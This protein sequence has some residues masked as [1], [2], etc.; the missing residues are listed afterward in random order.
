MS[1][2]PTPIAPG[3]SEASA[4]PAGFLQNL[5]DIY[6]APREA[7]TR[8]VRTGWLLPAL[9]YLVVTLAG[10]GIWI[11]H[12]DPNEFVKA[13]MEEFGGK[14]FENATPEERSQAIDMQSRMFTVSR[15]VRAAL[16]PVFAIL[17]PAAVLLFI[18]RFF[19]A[20]DVRFPQALAIVSWTFLAVE[21]V[22]TPLRLVVM[23][24]KGEWNI[25]PQLAVQASPGVWA[26][27]SWPKWQWGLLSVP[28]LFSLW[29]VFLLATGF[30]VA[31]RRSTGSALWGVL[32]P[33]VLLALGGVGVMAAFMS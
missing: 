31:T 10:T 21:L 25:E 30:A 26:D 19:Y 6:F 16:G 13:Q 11:S 33:W 27:P 20:G 8:I 28:D 5:I 2:S 17:V 4:K 22:T 24:L 15:W 18:F 29:M 23:W 14:R 1:E 3:T 12:V 7:F 9:A 32:V